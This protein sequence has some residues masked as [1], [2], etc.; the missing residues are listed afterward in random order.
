MANTSVTIA[1]SKVSNLP[2]P[3]MVGGFTKKFHVDYTDVNSGTGATDT[4]TMSLG[5]TSANWIVTRALAVVT[6][7]FAGTTAFSITLGTTTSTNCVLAATSLLTAGALVN[8]SGANVVN[9]VAASSGTSAIT[10]QA[11]FT[12]ATGGSP[13]ALTAGAVDIFVG[14]YDPTKIDGPNKNA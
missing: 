8:S 11:I 12:N 6:T 1:A 3:E 2:L 13:S 14:L 9:G 7:A 10:L 4:V 5:S